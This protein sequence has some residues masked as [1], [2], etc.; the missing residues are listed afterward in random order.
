MAWNAPRWLPVL[1][2]ALLALIVVPTA[3]SAQVFTPDQLSEMPQIDSPRDALRAIQESYPNRLRD[4]G[5][6]GRVQVSFVVTADGSVDPASVEVVQ[7]E[8]QEL[9]TAAISAIRQIKFK[10]GKKD[11]SAVA[12]RV[13]IPIAYT[14]S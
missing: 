8:N 9:G 4:R 6:E 12:S 13:V 14:V 2:L 7:T 1:G 10:P 5:I 11:G 3:G